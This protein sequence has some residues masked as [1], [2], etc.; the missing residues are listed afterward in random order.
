MQTRTKHFQLP[1]LESTLPMSPNKIRD[2][3]ER[4]SAMIEQQLNDHETLLKLEISL[5]SSDAAQQFATTKSKELA[6]DLVALTRHLPHHLALNILIEASTHSL[7][8]STESAHII[9]EGINKE[10]YKRSPLLTGELSFHFIQQLQIT[11]P[12]DVELFLVNPDMLLLWIEKASAAEISKVFQYFYH[13]ESEYL[14]H[15][16]TLAEEEYK[17]DSPAKAL[18]CYTM[19]CPGRLSEGG[20]ENVTKALEWLNAHEPANTYE[21]TARSLRACINAN[22]ENIANANNCYINLNKLEL[23][24]ANFE[25]LQ[26]HGASFKFAKMNSGIFVKSDMRGAL[27]DKA[28]LINAN[29]SHAN[30]AGASLTNAS[31]SHCL[32]DHT[33]LAHAN[34][35]GSDLSNAKFY[36]ADLASTD[37]AHANLE[38]A[39]FFTHEHLATPAALNAEL[40]RLH[41][42]ITGH[43]QEA[44][45]RFAIISDL[46]VRTK[47]MNNSMAN[48]N[49]SRMIKPLKVAYDHPICNQHKDLH[50]VKTGV[51][52]VLS[53]YHSFFKPVKADTPT[54]YETDE[55]KYLRMEIERR[56]NQ[57]AAPA[58]RPPHPDKPP[59]PPAPSPHK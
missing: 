59:T 29:F 50:A 22:N 24:R 7:F 39:A 52:L 1:Q 43:K 37:L 17:A 21:R 38:H 53:A 46:I 57:T 4:L 56:E 48:N 13:R 11:N 25:A 32:F 26:L 12:K 20:A 36:H 45:L 27:L 55:Q 6:E 14:K 51:N 23:P 30:L 15:M 40:N 8:Q 5:A 10:N 44:K 3:A 33:N 2:D 34:L 54:I 47:P 16:R 18:L 19:M 35:S 58:E 28:V 41:T 9:L 49:D 42:M 31:L